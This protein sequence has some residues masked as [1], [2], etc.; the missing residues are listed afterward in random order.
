[1][2]NTASGVSFNLRRREIGLLSARGFTK[3]NI[4]KLFITEAILIG[5]ISGLIGF[6][7]G[8]LLIPLVFGSAIPAGI[9]GLEYVLATAG[10]QTAIIT[11]VIGVF[12]SV[13]TIYRAASRA[14]GMKTIDALKEYAYVEQA[15]KPSVSKWVW[16]A[17]ILGTFKMIT[18]IIGLNIYALVA[19]MYSN[20][21]LYMLLVIYMI[22]DSFLSVFGP[23]LFLKVRLDSK[24][25]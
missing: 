6:L 2:G 19:S 23:I 17:F 13:F 9:Q 25:R 18:L 1:M 22:L 11:I 10:I 7:I 3:R 5:L 14:S 24:E 4:M 15:K 20:V 8:V 16:A 21:I 12:L